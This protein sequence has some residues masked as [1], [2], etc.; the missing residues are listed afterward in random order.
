[1]NELE[2]YIFDW[3]P[4][5]L[6]ADEKA[7]RRHLLFRRKIETAGS[8]SMKK[9]LGRRLSNDAKVLSLLENG[10]EKFYEK[11]VERVLRENPNREFLNLCPK[12]GALARTPQAKQ[13]PRCFYSWHEET[14]R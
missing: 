14:E 11:T 8:E 10:E 2:K 12:C 6:T 4:G 1:M 3:C 7:A 13:C 9:M 5:W